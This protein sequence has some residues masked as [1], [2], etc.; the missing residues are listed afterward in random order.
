M[1]EH[2]SAPGWP[3]ELVLDDEPGPAAYI[4][5]S[6][7]DGMIFGALEQAGLGHER[8]SGVGRR[9][10]VDKPGIGTRSLAAAALLVLLSVGSASAAVMWLGTRAAREAP[11][12]HVSRPSSAPRRALPPPA[13]P[14]E[15]TPT[16]VP[17]P[18]HDDEPVAHRARA[19]E[20]LLVEGNRLRAERR[21]ARADEAYARAAQQ[22]PHSQTAYVAQVAAAA[23][24]LEH[25]HDARGALA[26]YRAALQQAPDGPLREE[27]QWGIAEAYR[28]LGDRS[29]E[30]AALRM[31]MREHPRSPLLPQARARLD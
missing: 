11:P 30:R 7:A 8:V 2:E 19:P 4:T 3:R 15:E 18:A 25:L 21:W 12:A 22:A 16:V 10:E 5:R 6:Q 13:E 27:I 14:Q 24:R 20:D 26:R 29:S 28:A 23:V 1:S 31:F 17:E 9:G